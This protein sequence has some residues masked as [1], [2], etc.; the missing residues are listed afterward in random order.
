MMPLKFEVFYDPIAHIVI[1][2][3]F[4]EEEQD[5]AFVLI[6]YLENHMNYGKVLKK[7]DAEEKINEVN[8]ADKKVKNIW[9]YD[10]VE[11]NDDS[12]AKE[13]CQLIEKKM[14]SDQMLNIYA[15]CN[16]SLFQFYHMVNSSHILV[17]KYEKGDFYKWHHDIGM[18]ITGNIWLS[19]DNVEGG[20]F[21]LHKPNKISNPNE[22]KKTIKYK[23]NTCIL[24]PGRCDHMVSE[25]LNDSK[26]FSIQYFSQILDKYKEG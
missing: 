26:R 23:S 2:N 17:S 11:D 19:K 21:I 25:V 9:P 15:E 8:L 1:D 7:H 6:E 24:F 12:L 13:F 18:S 3:F 22:E 10:L 14:W 20:D 5:R 16:D 4:S